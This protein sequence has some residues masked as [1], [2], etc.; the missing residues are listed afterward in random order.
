LANTPTS[1]PYKRNAGMHRGD[2]MPVVPENT[3]FKLPLFVAVISAPGK[4]LFASEGLSRAHILAAVEG[5]LRRLQTDYI[6]LYQAHFFDEHVPIE[7]TLTAFDDL[8]HQGKVRYIGCS[9][10]PAWRL[11]QALWVS[12]KLGLARYASL[13]PHYNL[14][15]RTEFENELITICRT[16]GLGVIPYS[17]LAS[18]FLTGK[19]KKDAPNVGSQR[20][21]SHH[22]NDKNW[23][24]LQELEKIGRESGH[25]VSRI[26]LAWLLNQPIITCPIIGP[27]NLEQLADN[28]GALDVKLS[29][30]Q[31]DRLN[32]ISE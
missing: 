9:N 19:Y 3:F 32:Q 5:S 13:Q 18:G 16:Y 28:L 25:S 22:F 17:P 21:V 15:H 27:R 24:T 30:E 31:M 6:D 2:A 1:V 7:E 20:N 29:T 10:Y 8:I 14:I 12:D 26:S 11:M 4:V 23:A